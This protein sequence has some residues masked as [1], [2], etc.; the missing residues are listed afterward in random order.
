MLRGASAEC[1]GQALGAMLVSRLTLTRMAVTGCEM[2]CWRVALSLVLLLGIEAC[3][4]SANSL[5]G[6][7]RP[8]SGGIKRAAF[9]LQCP[10]DQLQAVELGLGTVGVAGCGKRAVYKYDGYHGWVNNTGAADDPQKS[11]SPAQTSSP[12]QN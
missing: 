5:E 8:E 11:G 12:A 7:N 4:P 2:R 10:Q 1:R 3:W 6:F 9:E